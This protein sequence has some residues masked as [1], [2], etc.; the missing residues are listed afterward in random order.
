MEIVPNVEWKFEGGFR[1][2]D[3]NIEH[4]VVLFTLQPKIDE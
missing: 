4:I 3:L 2:V 1:F